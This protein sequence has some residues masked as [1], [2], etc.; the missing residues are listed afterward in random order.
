M[1]QAYARMGSPDPR[2]N[3]HGDVDFRLTALYHSWRK[4]DAPP[5][6]VKPLP[7]PVVAQV[8]SLA[9]LETT[10]LAT[11]AAEILIIDFY[12][13][14][15]PGEYVGVPRPRSPLFRIQDVQLWIGSRALAVLTCS[16]AEILAATFVT[17]TFTT[18]KTASAMKPS[19]TG[20]PV[21][22]TC[23]RC[24][25]SRLASSDYAATWQ[26]L[27]SPSMRC[28]PTPPPHSST[29]WYPI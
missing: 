23:A 1:G 26:L 14:L 12:F 13:L 18:Q 20:V 25:V 17:L 21:T 24:I 15:R 7:I 5:S 10:P 16:D 22:L 3:P 27:T 4:D 19:A 9:Q 28:A 6:R 8:W 29:F 2:L 11:A